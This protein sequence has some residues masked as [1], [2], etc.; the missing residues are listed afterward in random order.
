MAKEFAAA[1]YKSSAWIKCRRSYIKHRISIDGGT[2]EECKEQL[3]YIVHH[4]ESLTPDNILNPDVSLNHKKLKYVCKDCHDKY[5]GH[6]VGS[7]DVPL[8]VIFDEM[9]QPISLREID[10]HPP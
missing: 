5:D 6:G 4:E 2:C 1:F 7:G 10:G 9:G 3:G 8:L